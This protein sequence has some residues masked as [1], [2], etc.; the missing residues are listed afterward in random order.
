MHI[1]TV[2]SQAFGSPQEENA[3]RT[4]HHGCPLVRAAGAAA[5]KAP[6]PPR[7]PAPA[8]VGGRGRELSVLGCRRRATAGQRLQAL[9]AHLRLCRQ[10]WG[11]G[12]AEAGPGTRGS[13]ALPRGRSPGPRV[14][15]PPAPAGAAPAAASRRPP[16]GPPPALGG[17]RAARKRLCSALIVAY[18]LFSLYAAYTVFLRPRRPAVPR[19]PHRD[20]RGPRGESGDGAAA[21]RPAAGEPAWPLPA[22]QPRGRRV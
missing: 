8:R 2:L 14:E 17:M 16:P 4:V 18:G 3:P 13:E 11:G 22:A 7:H 5:S 1:D 9:S 6:A 19:P 21:S 12:G 10:C 20:R 15:A